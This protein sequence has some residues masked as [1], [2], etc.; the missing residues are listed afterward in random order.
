[1]KTLNPIEDFFN[2]VARLYFELNQR[3]EEAYKMGPYS[4]A[5]RTILLIL[6][7]RGEAYADDLAQEFADPALSTQG[8]MII[9]EMAKSGLIQAEYR[10]GR[11]LLKL[12]ESGQKK[13]QD[14]VKYEALFAAHLPSDLSVADLR[15][16][17]NTMKQFRQISEDG[18][19]ASLLDHEKVAG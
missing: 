6:S 18:R 9:V 1:M 4:G 5:K 14:I 10:Q 12:T 11:T 7:Q 13:C 2:Q 17:A 8:P 19:S 15:K 16:A 3:A